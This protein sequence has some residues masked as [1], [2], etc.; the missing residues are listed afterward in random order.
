M[1]EPEESEKISFLGPLNLANFIFKYISVLFTSNHCPTGCSKVQQTNV[2]HAYANNLLMIVISFSEH[3]A[4]SDADTDS[5]NVNTG[6][7]NAFTDSFNA[8]T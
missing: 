5:F 3:T 2:F 7:F 8:Y 1:N 6:S 4:S